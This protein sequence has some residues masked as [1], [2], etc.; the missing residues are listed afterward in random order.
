MENPTDKTQKNEQSFQPEVIDHE[1]KEIEPSTAE[2]LGTIGLLAVGAFAVKKVWDSNIGN[3]QEK[4]HSAASEL[5]DSAI[6]TAKNK[7]S[8]SFRLEGS[9]NT[10]TKT[11][12]DVVTDTLVRNNPETK[13]LIND[14][15][16]IHN[17]DISIQDAENVLGDTFINSLE[18]KE[19]RFSSIADIDPNFAAKMQELSDESDEKIMSF[20]RQQNPTTRGIISAAFLSTEFGSEKEITHDDLIAKHTELLKD[21][22]YMK[23]FIENINIKAKNKGVNFFDISP[24]DQQIVMQESIDRYNINKSPKKPKNDLE[25]MKQEYERMLR[26]RN[27]VQEKLLK[28]LGLIVK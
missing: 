14:V 18:K 8:T 5:I 27:K 7:L 13:S 22:V 12:N 4:T 2:F 23:I 10:Q 6:I 26:E 11:R 28:L 25:I 9:N 21:E 1:K 15:K 17:G 3:V 20:I 24:E 19:N 16:S